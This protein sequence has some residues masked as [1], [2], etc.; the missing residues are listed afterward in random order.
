VLVD[1]FLFDDS[2]RRAARDDRGEQAG[3]AALLAVVGFQLLLG[4]ER[5]EIFGDPARA[6]FA[7]IDPEHVGD[8]EPDPLGLGQSARAEFAAGHLALVGLHD[9]YARLLE[10]LDVAL[11]RR[12]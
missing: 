7:W 5:L 4:L 12:V 10:P 2:P 8:L 9:A 6:G 11:G 1:G 3:E